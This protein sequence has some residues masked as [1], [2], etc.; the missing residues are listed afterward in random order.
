MCGRMCL[1]GVGMILALPGISKSFI[2]H[3]PPQQIKEWISA[4]HH[5]HLQVDGEPIDKVEED[6][7]SGKRWQDF[8]Q[9][10]E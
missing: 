7:V 3:P 6:L 2:H 4:L 9:P 5:L 10:S 1:L 8:Q